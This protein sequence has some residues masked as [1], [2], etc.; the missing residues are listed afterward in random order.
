MR[1]LVAVALACAASF[2]QQP[3]TPTFT[4]DI[5]PFVYA[6]CTRC[7]R[8]GEAGPFPL[9]TFRD[10]R[11][12]ALDEDNESDKTDDKGDE[13]GEMANLTAVVLNPESRCL[14]K[15]T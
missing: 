6:N 13:A 12:L 11:G 7:H 5:A 4:Q 9:I 8:P 10:V 2:A 1:S 15:F 3:A 14:V